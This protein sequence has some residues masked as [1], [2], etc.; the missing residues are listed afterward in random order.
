MTTKAYRLR[1][2]AAV[3][4]ASFAAIS[5]AGCGVLGSR[6]TP[7]NCAKVVDDM[8]LEQVTA[9]LGPPTDNKTIGVGPLSATT[10]TWEDQHM[11]INVKFLNDKSGL[12]TCTVKEAPA[13]KKNG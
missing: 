5:L 13:A 12:K 8:T 7:E 2:A 3:V 1:L 4:A 6:L 9:I 11:K 10:V